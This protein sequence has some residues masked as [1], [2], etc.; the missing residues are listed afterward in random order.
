MKLLHI[1]FTIFTLIVFCNNSNAQSEADPGALMRRVERLEQTQERIQL[2][3]AQHRAQFRTGTFIF[4][5]GLLASGM[6]LYLNNRQDTSSELIYVGGAA[7]L[8][9]GIIHIDSH[10]HI[11]RAGKAGK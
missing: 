3:L 11:G 9:G 7:M 6:G 1:L 5:S 2:H 10:K 8:L 4:L